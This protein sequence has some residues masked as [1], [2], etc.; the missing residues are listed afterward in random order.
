MLTPP[1]M[2]ALISAVNASNDAAT[3]AFVPSASKIGTSTAA[4]KQAVTIIEISTQPKIFN[5]YPM[6][7]NSSERAYLNSIFPHNRGSVC[8]KRTH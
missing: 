6:L 3:A 1:S 5:T 2:K 8:A 4:P 7:E